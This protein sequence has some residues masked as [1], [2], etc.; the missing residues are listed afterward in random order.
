MAIQSISAACN[1]LKTP[2]QVACFSPSRLCKAQ[3]LQPL[4]DA[5]GLVPGRLDHSRRNKALLPFS[6]LKPVKEVGLG[7][8]DDDRGA[9]PCMET[10]RCQG[11]LKAS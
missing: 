8:T 9:A 4:K 1:P 11:W 6:G 7:V 3:S 2:K 5:P 10:V